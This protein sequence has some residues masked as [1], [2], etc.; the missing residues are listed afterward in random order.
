MRA[1]VVLLAIATALLPEATFAMSERIDIALGCADDPQI[2][3]ACFSVNGRLSAYNGYPNLRIWPR[4]TRRLLGV[5]PNEEPRSIPP[6]IRHLVGFGRE[7]WGDFLVCPF[8]QA[9]AGHMQYVCVEA[10]SNVRVREY[11][12]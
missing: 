2:V 7:I 1:R 8:T 6:A 5:I 4:V 3:G 11:R 10:V 12:P 9:K